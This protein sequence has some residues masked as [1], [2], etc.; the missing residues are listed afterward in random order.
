M[1]D[2]NNYRVERNDSS[3]TM[4]EVLKGRRLK[5]YRVKVDGKPYDAALVWL[6]DHLEMALV[7]MAHDE[8]PLVMTMAGEDVVRQLLELYELT[9]GEQ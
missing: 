1:T 7:L 9:E 4:A 2:I 5:D 6:P 8:A 3:I